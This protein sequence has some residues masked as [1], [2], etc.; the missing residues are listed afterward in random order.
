MLRAR[1]QVISVTL[2]FLSDSYSVDPVPW[3]GVY[4]MTM[5]ENLTIGKLASA[6]DVS[7]ETVRFY[8]RTGILSQ[9]RKQGAFRQY[10]KE[11]IR[12]IRFIKRSQEL[13][14]T[15]QESKDLIDLR[16]KDQA[17]CDDVL[18]KTEEKIVEIKDKI[19][20][21]KKIEQSLMNLLKCCDDREAPLS[22]CPILDCFMEGK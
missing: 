16:I 18:S 10:P 6:S 22:D 4:V 1:A 2:Q 20:D 14:F 17:K 7:V 21:L 9:P 3:Y 12:H 13:G 5:K 11:Y 19:R 15:L 8:E